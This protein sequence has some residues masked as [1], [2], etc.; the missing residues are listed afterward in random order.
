MTIG[1]SC[2]TKR[3][4]TGPLICQVLH[5]GD[6]H[7]WAWKRGQISKGTFKRLREVTIHQPVHKYSNTL[8]TFTTVL[9]HNCWI[10]A[11]PKEREKSHILDVRTSLAVRKAEKFW[12]WFGVCCQIHFPVVLQGVVN[13]ESRLRPYLPSIFSLPHR[14]YLTSIR[15]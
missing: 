3:N 13:Y 6:R 5:L 1:I 11:W 8:T 10:L 9:M 15:L 4:S 2:S 7:Q 12:E 14:L